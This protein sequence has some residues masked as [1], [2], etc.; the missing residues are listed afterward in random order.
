VHAPAATP[1]VAADPVEANLASGR[2][3]LTGVP[4]RFAVQLMAADARERAYVAM[5]LADAERSLSAEKVFLAATGNPE[6]P[7]FGVLYGPFTGKA[8]AAEALAALPPSLKQFGPYIRS[9]DAVRD[10]SR[11]VERR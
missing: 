2:D 9:L 7:R 6:A 3:V 10:E 1:S 11:R 5:Y 8:E 4:G